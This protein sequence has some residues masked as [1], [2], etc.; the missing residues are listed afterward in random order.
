MH[1][2]ARLQGIELS[3]GESAGVA[4]TVKL[5]I[6]KDPAGD[7]IK[8]AVAAM[9]EGKKSG[10]I[11]SK[12]I[13]RKPQGSGITKVNSSYNEA[14][15]NNAKDGTKNIWV[16]QSM[17]EG[18]ADRTLMVQVSSFLLG[19]TERSKTS[20]YFDKL[21]RTVPGYD[22]TPDFWEI[23][24]WMGRAAA[25]QPNTDVY[26]VRNEEEAS[27]FI[28]DAGYGN[29]IFSAL[30]VAKPIITSLS[31]AN[32]DQK[33]QIGTYTP[34]SEVKDLKNV[35]TFTT[36]EEYA[37]QNGLDYKYAYNY[38]Q[39]EGTSSIPRIRTSEGCKF[40]CAFCSNV[41]KVAPMKWEEIQQQVDGIKMLDSKFVYVG[42]K[43]FGQADNLEVFEKIYD[44]IKK[45]NPD[46]EG[47]IVQTSALDFAN[48]K[49][50][51]PEFLAKSHI[52]Y[53][54]L[55][56]ETYNDD[57][58]TKIRKPHS[59]AKHVK[60]ALDN[61]RA[62]D[63][64]IIPNL[65]VGLSGKNPDGTVWSETEDTYK[66]TLDFLND[67]RDVISH[68]N[69]Y[70]LALYEGTE[71]GDEIGAKIEADKNENLAEKSFWSD[72]KVH[73]KYAGIFADWGFNQLD[74][75]ARPKLE[76][77]KAV[78]TQGFFSDVVTGKS[79]KYKPHTPWKPLLPVGTQD[80]SFIE[81]YNK[82]GGNFDEHIATSIPGF[83]DIQIKTGIAVA[84]LLPKGGLVYDIG[85]SEGTWIKTVTQRSEGA[86]K[87]ISVD[88][89]KDMVD[90]FNLSTVEGS[91]AV[92]EA[93][94]EGFED[95][96]ITYKV[97]EPKEKSRRST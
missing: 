46:F 45:Y 77:N 26:V 97:H 11:V 69:V 23:P 62:N 40:K 75:G 32:P 9:V 14:V 15:A 59:H 33:I 31:K 71:L 13:N 42:D 22:R 53:V 8:K 25:I 79:D 1:N 57:I 56:I 74:R 51:S 95:E 20:R 34:Y 80:A 61:A 3:E 38:P 96:G 47:F 41:K 24:T 48:T 52:K 85:G 35:T 81:D 54:E 65:I 5:L 21:Y 72:P 66:N 68:V 63:V 16:R 76:N 37:K 17:E 4:A 91:V 70:S 12:E 30:D 86:I 58:L 7:L 60:A 64:K 39:F 10:R 87:S 78:A 73:Q 92:A 27:R 18:N 84:K 2:E 93:F 6:G 43:A 49:R 36:L 19:E 90:S 67:N 89:N 44:E 50:M 28:K 29:V 55:G 83:R 88:P 94:Y 82:M